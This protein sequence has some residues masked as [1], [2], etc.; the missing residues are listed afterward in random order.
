M[1]KINIMSCNHVYDAV[2]EIIL[3][4]TKFK[5]ILNLSYGKILTYQLCYISLIYFVLSI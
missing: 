3:Y 2:I 1:S 5:L 4:V